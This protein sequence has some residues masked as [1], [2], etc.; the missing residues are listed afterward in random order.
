MNPTRLL[1]SAATLAL[2]IAAAQARGTAPCPA[3]T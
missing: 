2:G 3:D 1:M